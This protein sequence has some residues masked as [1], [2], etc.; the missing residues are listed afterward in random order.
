MNISVFGLGYVGA[1]TSACLAEQGHRVIGVDLHA[2][3]VEA[4]G[5]GQSPIIEPEIDDLLKR[6]TEGNRLG[7]TLDVHAAVAETDVSI[8]CVG[9]P[10][11]PSG[12]LNLDF[13]H[14]VTGQIARAIRDTRKSHILLY[15]STMLPGSTRSLVTGMLADLVA[16]GQIRVY[17]CPEFLRE[18]TAVKDFREPSLVVIGTNDGAAPA[19]AEVCEIMGTSPSILAWEGAEMIKYSCNYFHA[20]KVGFANEIGRL[21][22]HLGEDGTR[23]MDV[24]CADTR[25]NISH[26]YM[27]P[28]NPFGGSCLPKDVSALKSFAR[29]ENISLPLLDNTAATNA[30][31]QDLFVSL[32][33][34]KGKRRI[35]FLGLAFKADTDDLRG[36]PMVA[37]AETLLGRG[38]ELR[39]YDPHI[40]LSRL[41]GSNE[42]QIQKRMPH[43]AQLM[44]TTPAEV[45]Q[46]S[47][48]IVVSQKCTTLDLL[49]TEARADHA[50]I[51]VN[52]WRELDALPWQYEGI[53][54]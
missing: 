45:L 29:Q 23:V 2:A 48:V 31:H 21:C 43:L 20:L 34:S 30:A 9:T 12:R 52:G 24:L 5:R 26:Y 13:V 35:G 38:H 41:I 25:L 11:L 27:K 33:E 51:D 32:I 36:S 7:A 46:E 28:G 4:F 19:D 3:K 42:Q 54:W 14:K 17:Y 10:S 50:V 53:C 15:R 37:A 8:V 1:V 39:I 49:R 22:K 40:N 47:D 44:K 16:S 6:A 18:G